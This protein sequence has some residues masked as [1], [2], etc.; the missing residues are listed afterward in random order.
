[1][2]L[3]W[4]DGTLSPDGGTVVA[5]ETSA[6]SESPL[7][8]YFMDTVSQRRLGDALPPSQQ[9]QVSKVDFDVKWSEDSS[10]VAAKISY[11]TK[12]NE[13]MVYRK[14]KDGEIVL[15][16]INNPPD[17][18]M[19]ESLSCDAAKEILQ[20]GGW[21]ENSLGRWLW[22]RGIV[23]IFGEAKETEMGVMHFFVV[24][25]AEIVND[26]CVLTVLDKK[27]HLTDDLAD[28]FVSKWQSVGK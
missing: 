17:P 8:F 18:L 25:R 28:R 20:S 14:G 6:D 9:G 5:F 11:G 21:S 15:V 7:K 13:L 12:F 16:P 19:V 3:K 23:L 24:T 27:G 26:R 4:V 2:N 1:M 22:D 10:V